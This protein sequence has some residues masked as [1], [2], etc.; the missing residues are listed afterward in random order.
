MKEIRPW[1]FPLLNPGPWGPRSTD[2]KPLSSSK[3]RHLGHTIDCLM[4]PDARGCQG[5]GGRGAWT[6]IRGG[7]P[8]WGVGGYIRIKLTLCRGLG[9]T[10]S[11]G[12]RWHLCSAHYYDKI[13]RRGLIVTMFCHSLPWEVEKVCPRRNSKGG[14]VGSGLA[15]VTRHGAVKW[16]AGDV[17]GSGARRKG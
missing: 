16:W 8:G 7:R 12:R 15:V 14:S 4:L 17:T 1:P 9:S 6:R 11:G 13:S 2:C 5:R 3:P 10:R